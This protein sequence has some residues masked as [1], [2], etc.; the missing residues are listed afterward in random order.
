M[1]KNR[2][3]KAMQI[4]Y[5]KATQTRYYI[6]VDFHKKHSSVAV[7]NKEGIIKDERKL[8]HADKEGLAKYFSSFGKQASVSIE[9]TRNWYWFVDL[10][11]SLSLKVKLVHAKKARIIA[12]STVKTD[13]I[14]ARVL[15]NLDRCNFLP[16]SYISNK[17][18]RTMRELLRYY[19]SLVK[20]RTSTKN[21][22][23]SVLDKNNIQHNFSDLFGKSGIEFLK[24]IELP[25]IFRIELD[26]YLNVLNNLK[27][28]IEK[29][30][31]EIKTKCKTSDYAKLLMTIPGISYFSALLLAAEIGEI[32]RFKNVG[33]FC[34]YSGFASSTYQSADTTYH[35]RI[36]K[37]ADKYIRY[38]LV[39]AV[40]HAT[41]KDPILF[42]Y[43]NK[44]KLKK[45]N[46]K[47]KI[48]TARKLCHRIYAMLK[49]KQNYQI[50]FNSFRVSDF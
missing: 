4:R 34:R 40:Q 43:Y 31:E 30:E 39:E 7:M 27:E 49:R 19:M 26:G 12:E 42:A 32:D 5:T 50:G 22:I 20:M 48:A 37:D 1:I 29:A 47:A 44:I 38:V 8:Y 41:K 25:E 28:Q 9:A 18:T 10:L 11:Q 17:K 46:G 45:G 33:K 3:T 21:R 16:Q 2:N 13:K 35:G 14:D 15:A 24:Q 23:H 6:G 36:I